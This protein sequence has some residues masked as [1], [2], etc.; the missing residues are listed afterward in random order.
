MVVAVEDTSAERQRRSETEAI[1]QERRRIAQEIHDGIAQGMAALRLRISVWHDMVE[2]NPAQLH[3]E[4]DELQAALDTGM[5]EMRR[6]IYA[7][8]PVALDEV[9]L[10]PAL[11]QLAADFENQHQVYVELDI[12]GPEERLP[13][14]LELPLFRVVQEALHNIGKHAQASLVWLALDLTRDEAIK[15]TIRDNGLGF[16]PAS[17]EGAARDGHLGLKQMRE[18]VEEAQGRL[19]LVSRPGQGTEVRI[20]LA[21]G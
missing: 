5:A 13:S 8:R 6:A 1:D 16:D 15:L 18:R 17:L 14:R 7:L 2:A 3:A 4:L 21:L 19:E 10:F 9:G 11:H 12:S 20:V